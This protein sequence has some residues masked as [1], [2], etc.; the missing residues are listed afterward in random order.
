MI[1]TGLKKAWLVSGP[2]DMRKSFEG[3]AGIVEALAPGTLTDGDVYLFCNRTRTRV[4]ALY[5]DGSGLWCCAKRLERGRFRWMD[6]SKGS[7]VVLSEDEFLMIVR[8]LDPAD[9]HQKK[10]FRKE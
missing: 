7:R 9:F 6:D 5:W 4:K 2:T 1:G 8:G 10:W 3:L